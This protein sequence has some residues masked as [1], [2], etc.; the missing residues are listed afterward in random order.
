MFDGNSREKGRRSEDGARVS[1]NSIQGGTTRNRKD[2]ALDLLDSLLT[3]THHRMDARAVCR[4][5]CACAHHEMTPERRTGSHR[6]FGNQEVS[7]ILH[8][9]V[10]GFSVRYHERG[11]EDEEN[12]GKKLEREP[13]DKGNGL[14]PIKDLKLVYKAVKLRI[15][16]LWDY[17]Q[18]QHDNI[19]DGSYDP[20]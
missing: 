13:V 8:P 4:Q 2:Q 20:G 12:T 11:I 5:R 6:Y 3:V 19:R 17:L 9:R 1:R 18:S 10:E 14:M 15:A 7:P 16:P